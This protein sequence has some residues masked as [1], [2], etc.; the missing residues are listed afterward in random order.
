MRLRSKAA[1]LL[2]VVFA[3]ATP[4]R[5]S[6]FVLMSER[7]LAARSV[8]ALTGWVTDIEAVADSA[9]GG[10]NTYVHIE[11]TDIVFGSLPD[12]TVILRE[13]GGR[14]RGQ[15]EWIFGSAEYRVG[16]EVLVFVSQNPDGTLRTT[17]MS[18][19]KFTIAPDDRGIPN[20]ERRLGEGAA[21]WDL[22]RGQLVTEPGPEVYDL[23][24]L[25]DAVRTAAPARAALQAA[26]SLPK[27]TPPELTRAVVREHQEAFTY[28][29]TPSRWFEPDDGVPISYLIDGTGDV[30]LGAV[31]SRAAIN[32]A[33]AAW[34]NVPTAS[35]ALADGGTL[36]QATTFAGCDGGNRIMFNDPFNEVTDPS[37]CSGIL[38][39]GGF[40]SSSETRTVNGTSFRRIRVGKITFNN[41]WSSC[42][43]WSRCN[44]SEV[45][46]H[47]LGHTIGFGH[48]TDTN[49]TMYAA[50]HFDGRCASLRTDD[51][52][53]VNFVYPLSGVAPSPTATPLP[54][55]PTF[56]ATRT[57]TPTVPPPTPTRTSTATLLPPTA[58]RTLAPTVPTPTISA[59]GTVT[60]TRTATATSTVPN[61]PTA[62]LPPTATPTLGPRHNVLGHVMYGSSARGVPDV[63]VKLNG[64]SSD[65]TLTTAAGDYAF[66]AVPE[67]QWEIAAQKGSEGGA[68]VSPLDAAYVLQAVASLRAFDANQRLACDVTGDGQL[69]A[70]DATRILQFSVGV[71]PRL[72][73][74]TTCGSDW[75]FM[76]EPPVSQQQSVIDP[77]IA[78]GSCS[79]GKIMLGD[80]V[81]DAADQNFHAILF[82]DCTGNWG[83]ASGAALEAPSRT[84]PRVRL[85]RPI[86]TRTHVQVP[87]YLHSA[88][89]YHALDLQIGYDSTRL[90][91]TTVKLRRSNDPGM[92]SYHAEAGL[93]HVAMASG[94]PLTRSS[95][96]LLLLEFD[97]L[98]SGDPGLRLLAASVDE[99]PAALR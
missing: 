73:V 35:I 56:T 6:T 12:G 24:G 95:G 49:A 14:L 5:A 88:A 71:I 58:T 30:G 50:A 20:A 70:L 59:T 37:G 27:I 68:A 22:E 32:D 26:R 80:L 16:E 13:P 8:A 23:Q 46:T 89:P 28:L 63:M 86:G 76:P 97:R 87:V 7:D 17:G 64:A 90:A 21:L 83:P 75:T 38:A 10:V 11:P 57:F 91:P 42:P 92:L 60:L 3:C 25:L 99:H 33:F 48:S 31:T 19:G 18:M 78:G 45:A 84:A 85:G 36:P 54:P 39:V 41:G 94:E 29:S 96:I 62:S 65:S 61:T 43:G 51:L 74:A 1:V 67:G 66:D 47:E 40:C 69:S 55:T 72:P 34:T 53:A 9:T 2:M 4:G 79:D 52:A 44:L 93:L 98:A 77:A 82:G 81:Q 15:S